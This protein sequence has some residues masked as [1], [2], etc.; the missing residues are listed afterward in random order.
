MWVVEM[1]EVAGVCM[2]GCKQEWRH[3]G[4]V[5][6][7]EEV[8]GVCMGGCKQEWRHVGGG[9]GGSSRGVHGRV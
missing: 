2:G 4:R 7:M 9:D 1:E 3:V 6:E 8:A 5:V